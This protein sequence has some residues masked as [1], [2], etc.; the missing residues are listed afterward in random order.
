[1]KSQPRV[2][3]AVNTI[4]E[5]LEYADEV[6]KDDEEL[7]L[8]AYRNSGNALQYASSTLRKYFVDNDIR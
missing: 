8:I 4:G 5:A 7:V 1:L 3:T 2:L 6:F